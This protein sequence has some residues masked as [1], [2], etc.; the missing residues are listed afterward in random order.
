MF[1]FN[2]Q[3]PLIEGPVE[4]DFSVQVDRPA[5]LVFQLVDVSDP[6][7]SQ[8]ALGNAVKQITDDMYE[9]ALADMED[10]S[11]RF[12]VLE[13]VKGKR[14]MSKVMIEPRIGNLVEAIEDYQLTPLG[15]DRC[16][17]KLITKATFSDDLSDEEIAEEVAMMSMAV[18]EDLTKLKIHAEQGVKAVHAYNEEQDNTGFDLEFDLGD[19]DIDWDHIETEQ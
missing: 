9:I 7:F 4:F 16:V 6:G 14:H 1:G 10:L 12:Q 2:K 19:L 18:E 15:D 5:A 8:V 17:V 13:Y 11:F 3:K